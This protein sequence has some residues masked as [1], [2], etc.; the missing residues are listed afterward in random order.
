MDEPNA[1]QEGRG[2][3]NLGTKNVRNGLTQIIKL[4]GRRANAMRQ[5]AITD[6]T[7]TERER[8]PRQTGQRRVLLVSC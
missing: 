5:Q 7:S 3:S 1:V 4:E 8:H 6:T 2:S